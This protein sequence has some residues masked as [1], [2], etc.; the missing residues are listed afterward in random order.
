MNIKERNEL[1]H[2]L[3]E[4]LH[5]TVATYDKLTREKGYTPIPGYG[6]ENFESKEAIRRRITIMREELLQ[7]SKSL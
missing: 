7:L 1:I 6:C 4:E 2:L 5:Q 3:G